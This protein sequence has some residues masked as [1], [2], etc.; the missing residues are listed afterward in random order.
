MPPPATATLSDFWS[1][2]AD[3]ADS[4]GTTPGGHLPEDWEGWLREM[5]PGSVRSPFADHHGEFW[6]HV[7]SIRAGERPPAAVFILPRGGAKSTSAELA[8]LALGARGIRRYCIYLCA[9]QE[10]ADERVDTIGLLLESEA[11]LAHYPA[12]ARRQV[13]KYGRARAWRRSRLW[14]SSGFVVDALG[15]DTAAA[16]GRKILETRPDLII[17][18]EIDALHDTQLATRKKLDTFTNTILPMG[19]NHCAVICLQNLIIPDGVFAQLA[20][21]RATFLIDRKVVGPIPAIRNLK[22]QPKTMPSGLIGSEIVSGEAT[23]E[24]QNLEACQA[25]IDR[26]GLPS[27]LREQQHEVGEV[28]G[29]LWNRKMIRR[30]SE[31]PDLVRIVVGVDP[32]GGRAEIGIIVVGLGRDGFLY[33]L[34]DWTQP[35]RLGSLNWGTKAVWAW[36]GGGDPRFH[37]D[38]IAAESNFGGDMVESNILSAAG[39]RVPVLMVPASRGKHIRAEPLSTEY[40][41]GRVFHVGTFPELETEMC[42][43]RPEAGMD[44]PNRLDALVFAATE[45]LNPT[46]RVQSF[47]GHRPR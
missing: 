39:K 23:W 37:A 35:G 1:G 32:S 20:D 43:W 19:S 40:G 29:A 30:T 5:F 27:F 14:T 9:T 25:L 15:L 7:W 44:S 11:V 13:G 46:G 17:P 18:D 47:Q 16:R 22:T 42:R 8:A 45:I 38:V 21:G 33:V 28:E 34:D 31:A 3:L 10:Q 26:L 12:L 24:G 41:K 2:L 4:P 36:E 6:D